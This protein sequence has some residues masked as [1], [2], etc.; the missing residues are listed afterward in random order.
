M[1]EDEKTCPKCAE[2][3][4][5]AAVICRYCGH[6]FATE[7][8]ATI[9]AT[10]VPPTALSRPAKFIL[11]VL[12]LVAFLGALGAIAGNDSHPKS[13]SEVAAAA[14]DASPAAAANVEM[15]AEAAL[16]DTAGSGQAA[17]ADVIGPRSNALRSAQ[18]YINMTAFSRDGLIDQLSSSSGEGYSRADSVAA[19]D[20]LDVDWNEQAAKSAAKYLEMQC[21]SCDGLIQQLSSSS[22]E[23]FTRAQATFGAKQAGA[24]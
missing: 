13:S 23:K 4:K 17:A 5:A 22:G 16:G 10:A 9:S 3:V 11:G 24:C 2:T 21:F 12:G 18:Q 15:P 14:M 1:N 6:D 20:S 7:Q 8:T 19:V